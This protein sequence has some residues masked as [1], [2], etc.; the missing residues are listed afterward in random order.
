MQITMKVRIT[1]ND[2]SNWCVRWWPSAFVPTLQVCS[3]CLKLGKQ[4]AFLSQAWRVRGKYKQSRH[5]FDSAEAGWGRARCDFPMLSIFVPAHTSY[6]LCERF[7]FSWIALVESLILSS[8][9]P[10]FPAF[11]KENTSRSLQIL[12]ADQFSF[13]SQLQ[14]F[15]PGYLQMKPIPRMPREQHLGQHRM[16]SVNQM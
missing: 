9:I 1:L 12:P 8:Q 7:V 13:D 14:G 10:S 15:L 4:R 3:V 6:R 5:A 11:C 2:R 16:K